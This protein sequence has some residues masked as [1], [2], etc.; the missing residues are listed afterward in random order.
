VRYQF[1]DNPYLTDIRFGVRLADRDALTQNSNP[2][3]NWAAVT[4]ALD[5][6]AGTPDIGGKLSTSEMGEAILANL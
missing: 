6:G 3:Y 2:N 4:K 1:Q 5:S